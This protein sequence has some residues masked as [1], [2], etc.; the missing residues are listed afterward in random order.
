MSLSLPHI[1]PVS[2]HNWNHFDV[3]QMGGG[4]GGR[5]KKMKGLLQ[6]SYRD[7]KES[8]GNIV[9]SVLTMYGVRRV[10]GLSG[11]SLGKLYNV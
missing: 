2:F 10:Q 7:V 5:V 6:D 3:C 1:Q 11:Q 9:S 4:L 8:T